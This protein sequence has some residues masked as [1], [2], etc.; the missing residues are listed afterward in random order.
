MLFP[1]LFSLQ[2]F[3]GYKILAV[4][5]ALALVTAMAPP[6]WAVG[7]SNIAQ[8]K[9]A[10]LIPASKIASVIDQAKGKRSAVLIYAS[11]CPYCRKMMPDMVKIAKA[12]PG[13]VIAISVDK[14]ADTL[15]RYLDKSFGATPFPP[16][17]WDQSDIL[18]KELSRFGIKP[19]RGIPF[20]AM[21]DEYGFVHQQGV[22][23]PETVQSYLAGGLR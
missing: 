2:V 9:A 10:Y 12:Y 15:K 14:E 11:W 7:E 3:K 17:V 18:A 21:L 13:Q 16:I 8:Q 23:D 19:G 6:S 5:L 20:T 4:I 22:L 1:A